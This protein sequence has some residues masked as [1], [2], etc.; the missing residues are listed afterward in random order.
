[1][2]D[3]P[4]TTEVED[5]IR[6]DILAQEALRGVVKKV[7]KEVART[8]LPGEHHFYITFDTQYA[9]VRMSN[10]M[11]EHLALVVMVM[12]GGRHVQG[13]PPWTA[14]AL[15]RELRMPMR[16]IDE[17]VRPLE[18]RG[19]LAATGD[20]PPGWLPLRDLHEVSAKELLDTVRAAGEDEHMSLD[21]LPEAAP[22]RELLNRFDEAHAAALQEVSV[23]DLVAQLPED[24]QVGEA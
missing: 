3:T 15:A 7:L 1:M 12:I 20:A 22:V 11:R 13:Q 21:L 5:L 23:N 4:N 24:K 16:A 2:P 8:G 6:Y 9:G 19:I 10:R 14:A 17:V 18:A